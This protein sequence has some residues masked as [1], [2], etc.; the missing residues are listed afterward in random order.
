MRAVRERDIEDRL[1]LKLTQRG[2]LCLKFYS[3]GF[4]G[5]PDRICLLQGGR[6]A[7]VELKA[8][9]KMP[10]PHQARRHALL[11]ALGFQVEVIDTYAG[12]DQFVE[13]V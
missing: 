5:L 9:G 13:K 8:P 2:H 6:V 11:R 7:F 10:E 12:V 1:R 4:S 3:P